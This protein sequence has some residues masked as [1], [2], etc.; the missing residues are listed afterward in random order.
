VLDEAAASGS[1]VGMR[2]ILVRWRIIAYAEQR[3]QGQYFRVLAAA[4]RTQAT[5]QAP[6]GSVSG[7]EILALI[8]KRLGITR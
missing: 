2:D 6:P 4:A 7:E 3:D 8:N 5:G 1:L